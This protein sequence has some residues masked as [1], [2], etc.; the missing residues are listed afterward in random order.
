MKS[1]A[2]VKN[3]NVESDTMIREIVNHEKKAGLDE[4]TA[5]LRSLMA[6]WMD[7]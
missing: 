3:S 4:S 7:C 5:L 1:T 6:T 2:N